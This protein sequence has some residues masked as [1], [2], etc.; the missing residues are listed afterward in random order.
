MLKIQ[1]TYVLHKTVS[2]LISNELYSKDL[3]GGE[4]TAILS[5]GNIL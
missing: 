3:S 1:L 4:R 5:L 2:G